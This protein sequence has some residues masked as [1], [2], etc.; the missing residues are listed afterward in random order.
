MTLL[1]PYRVLDLT[2][3]RGLDQADLDM[4]CGNAETILPRGYKIRP[5]D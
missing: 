4:A 1:A 3:V 2:D 5:C